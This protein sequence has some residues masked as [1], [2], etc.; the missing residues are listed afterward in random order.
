[1]DRLH[2]MRVFAKVIDEG[3]FAAAARAMDVSA[4]AVTRLVADLESHLEVRLIHRS[5]RRL[6]LTPTG[7]GYLERVR[8]ILKQL[9]EAEAQVDATVR[10]PQGVVKVSVPAAAVARLLGSRLPALQQQHRGLDLSLKVADSPADADG[11]IALLLGGGN[12]PSTLDPDTV[13]RA[14]LR[15]PG[16]LCAS[17]RYLERAGVPQRPADLQRHDCLLAPL[18]GSGPTPT[19]RLAAP[20]GSKPAVQPAEIRT[21]SPLSAQH[22]DTLYAAALGG[23]GIVGLPALLVEDAIAEGRLVP[24]LQAW[25]APAFTL[26]AAMPSRKFVPARTRAVMDFLAHGLK[27]D[28]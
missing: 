6:S 27:T 14:V 25:T 3:G 11:D 23:L 22:P 15:S 4:A 12:A 16:V 2:S 19:W 21:N 13:T 7:Q 10:A 1:M 24:V 17:P 9:D 8:S 28:A 5:T 20:E 18:D 26:Y